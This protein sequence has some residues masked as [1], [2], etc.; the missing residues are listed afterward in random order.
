MRPIQREH[1]TIESILLL[2]QKVLG[3]HFEAYRNHVYRVFN[4]T[5]LLDSNF[6]ENHET[7]AIAAAFHDLGIWTHNTFDYLEPAI[8]ITKKYLSET[9]QQHLEEE[10]VLMINMHHKMSNYHGKYSNTVETFRKADCID[11]CMGMIQFNLNRK[12][13]LKVRTSFPYKGFHR[14][15]VRQ[16]LKRFLRYPFDPLPM[17]KR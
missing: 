2:Y 9:H 15:L 12:E 6:E 10:I 4:F 1:P 13:H 11:V 16:T 8:A 17:F 7:Y 14:F 5:A 3:K